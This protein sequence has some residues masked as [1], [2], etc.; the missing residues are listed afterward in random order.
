MLSMEREKK[1]VNLVNQKGIVSVEEVMSLSHISKTTAHRYI[2]ALDARKQIVK[3]RGGARSILPEGSAAATPTCEEE[4]S[5][6]TKD[7]FSQE[8]KRRIAQA[9]Q[10][11]ISPGDR[12]MLDSGSTTLELAKVLDKNLH[13][14]LITNDL[15]IAITLGSH[16]NL[17]MLFVG[18]MIRKGFYSSYSYFAES[19]LNCL[20]IDKLFFSVDAVSPDLSLMNYTLDDINL[21][22][23][24]ISK[25]KEAILLCDHSKFSANARFAFE[26]LDAVS[27]IIVDSGLSPDI[28]RRL[29][30]LGKRLLIV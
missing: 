8:E 5:L 18:G 27:T 13:G 10:S 7:L 12:I 15:R 19:M 28:Q 25:A 20:V 30:R 6:E 26:K 29:R 9:A 4:P 1:I 24:C 16:Q 23:N 2:S 22:K 3:I 21:K 11:L 14:T 17:D